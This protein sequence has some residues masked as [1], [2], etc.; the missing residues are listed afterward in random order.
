MFQILDST[1]NK[2]QV[3]QGID[4]TFRDK[5]AVALR[6]VNE[7]DGDKHKYFQED[8]YYSASEVGKVCDRQKVYSYASGKEAKEEF[9]DSTLFIFL[10][11]NAI[12][13]FL[14][15]VAANMEGVE[16]H[17]NFSCRKC[18]KNY[19][20]YQA[21]CDCGSELYYD[22]IYKRRPEDYYRVRTDLI[23]YYPEENIKETLEFKSTGNIDRVNPALGGKPWPDHVIQGMLG[24]LANDCD[25]VR[26]V[27]ISKSGRTLSD[28]IVEHVYKVDRQVLDPILIRMRRIGQTIDLVREMKAKG[29][30]VFNLVEVQSIAR[31]ADCKTA[32][33]K[34]AQNCP[35]VGICHGKK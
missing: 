2:F 7:A 27:Y 21:K 30:K 19:E 26:I 8:S 22:E 10:M 4:T 3:S 20:V 11:G 14:Q 33:S 5:F 1:E 31:H 23:L 13:H 28:S 9:D 25:R 24:A 12:H 32:R 29:E 15:K 35:F 34:I 17:G 16:V 6:K 18:D